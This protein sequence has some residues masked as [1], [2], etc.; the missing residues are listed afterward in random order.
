[1]QK[2]DVHMQHSWNVFPKHEQVSTSCTAHPLHC[3]HNDDRC[4]HSSV[5]PVQVEDKQ[6]CCKASLHINKH[7]ILQHGTVLI[8]LQD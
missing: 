6:S 7:V 5:I 8:G 3:K 4:N 2:H 1:M